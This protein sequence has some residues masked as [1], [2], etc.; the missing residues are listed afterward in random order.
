[1]VEIIEKYNSSQRRLMKAASKKKNPERFITERER[2]L[3]ID[4]LFF[5]LS[6]KEFFTV[7]VKQKHHRLTTAPL[8]IYNLIYF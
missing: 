4:T 2:V 3:S 5:Y 8:L 6:D 1:M 7:K